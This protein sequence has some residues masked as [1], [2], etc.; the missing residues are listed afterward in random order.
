LADPSISVVSVCRVYAE[1]AGG[2]Q[3]SILWSSLARVRVRI[4]PCWCN[5]PHGAIICG[6]SGEPYDPLDARRLAESVARA[7][8][9]EGVG[10]LPAAE[11]FSG[12]GIYAIYYTGG[13]EPYRLL[14]ERNREDRYEVPI[15]VGKAIPGGRRKG[16]GGFEIPPTRAL[17]GRL[18]EHA[19]T[20]TLATN[21]DVQDFRC[22]YLVVSRS[23]FPSARKCSSAGSRHY[24]TCLLMGSETMI[25][26]RGATIR[27]GR[28]GT[29]CIRVE[30]GL[31]SCSR[32]PGARR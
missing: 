29:C 4:I 15:Y 12:T 1:A 26:G 18:R 32:T 16:G 5:P 27:R 3:I 6:V 10:P 22:R 9:A 23:G 25:R 13:F 11:S 7:L 24:G 2:C 21:L 14:A 30:G 8:L 17:Y 20:I 28:F 31:R 19:A